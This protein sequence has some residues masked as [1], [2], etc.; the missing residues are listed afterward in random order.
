MNDED[1]RFNVLRKT[2][3]VKELR[4]L[5][6]VDQMSRNLCS[7]RA[8][9]HDLFIEQG[10]FLPQDH[11]TTVEEWLIEYEKELI[12]QDYIHIILRVLMNPK[13]ED[14]VNDYGEPVNPDFD[15]NQLYINNVAFTLL[16]FDEMDYFIKKIWNQWLIV[17]YKKY[18]HTAD[19]QI[20]LTLKNNQY[21]ITF[22]ISSN[23]DDYNHYIYPISKQSLIN[24]CH[25]LLGY[26]AEF[27]NVNA[28]RLR[29]Y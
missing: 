25:Q 7:Q 2:T 22:S 29:L 26:N 20:K 8:F 18:I 27:I 14:F 17:L 21:T 28:D 1:V 5:C 23:G 9:W 13:T 6:N 15:D 11:Y 4:H 24:I 19:P 3:D 12:L 16:N 10:L